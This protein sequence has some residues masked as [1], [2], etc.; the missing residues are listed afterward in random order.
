MDPQDFKTPHLTFTDIS[1]K[2]L[3]FCD[4]RLSRLS[5]EELLLA[6]G[7]PETDF[8]TRAD[9]KPLEK[10]VPTQLVESAQWTG[11]PLNENEDECEDEDDNIR[12]ID[13]GEAFDENAR[14][15]K[16]AQPGGLQAPETIFTGR[17]DYRQDLWRAGLVVRH[18]LSTLG[19]TELKRV[20]SFILLSSE[21][22]R[23]AGG[24]SIPW[25]RR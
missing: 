17:L 7:A 5:E 24:V 23:T 2:N 25:L 15:E 6:L 3:A 16:L 9:G 13:L 8:L 11:W 20:A 10:G 1:T 4:S 12:I 19:T 18:P 21:H 22:C 14:P